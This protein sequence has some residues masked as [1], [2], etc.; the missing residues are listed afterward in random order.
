MARNN[1]LLFILVFLMCAV[2]L[3]TYLLFMYPKLNIKFW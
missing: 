2:F 3:V 1:S